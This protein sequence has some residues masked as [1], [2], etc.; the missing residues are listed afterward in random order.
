MDLNMLQ[1]IN[2]L[3]SGFKLFK[4]NATSLLDPVDA[5]SSIIF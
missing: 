1:V 2:I 4:R 3:I 5:Q